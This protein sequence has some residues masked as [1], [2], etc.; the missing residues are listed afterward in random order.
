MGRC[1]DYVL[2]NDFKCLRVFIHASLEKRARRIVDVYGARKDSPKKRL[3]RK[4]KKRKAYYK[5]YTE[6]D[7]G[8]AKN[9]HI[10]LDSGAL[11]IEKC[12]DIITT[13]YNHE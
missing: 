1:A 8:I 12:V 10:A 2:Q 9:Y 4:D 11:G 6:T 7:W 5:Y 13:I 3:R